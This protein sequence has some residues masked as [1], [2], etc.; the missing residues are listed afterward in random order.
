LDAQPSDCD[1]AAIDAYRSTLAGVV[2]PQDLLYGLN[3][4]HSIS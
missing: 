1:L 2:D 4:S 3:R